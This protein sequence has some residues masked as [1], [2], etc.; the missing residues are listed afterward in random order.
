MRLPQLD[1][2]HTRGYFSYPPP[3][4][5]FQEQRAVTDRAY[6]FSYSDDGAGINT[7]PDISF[8]ETCVN[9]NSMGL[10]SLNI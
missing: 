1:R 2:G 9:T 6:S 10:G 7:Y 5:R 8:F 4:R 3:I